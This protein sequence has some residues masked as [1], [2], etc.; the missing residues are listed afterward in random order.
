MTENPYAQNLGSMSAESAFDFFDN[1]GKKSEVEKVVPVQQPKVQQKAPEEVVTNQN[2]VYTQESV[3]RNVNWNVGS[4]SMIKRNLLIGN[5]QY[6]AEVALK[7]G[8][9]AEAFLIAEMGGSQMLKDIQN[10]Y[11]EQ[12]KDPYVNNILKQLFNRSYG[13]VIIPEDK[14]VLEQMPTWQEKI[15]YVYTYVTAEEK[16]E[17]LIY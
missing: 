10:K 16:R 13:N 6:A 1:L 11:F 4:E 14:Q 8:R 9:T 5:Y 12:Q 17:E 3:S 15:A 7:I 2:E